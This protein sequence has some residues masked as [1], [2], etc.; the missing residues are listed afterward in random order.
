MGGREIVVGTSEGDVRGEGLA[1]S[2]LFQFSFSLK[3]SSIF[4]GTRWKIEGS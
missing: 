1:I 2:F 3:H 4:L